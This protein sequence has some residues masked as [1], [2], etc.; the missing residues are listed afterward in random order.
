MRFRESLP[1]INQ[2]S[3]VTAA[4]MLAFAL[5]QLVSFPAQLISLTVLG[6]LV[7]I[8][9][10]FN[11]VV[12][13]LTAVLAAA[14]MDWLIQSHPEKGEYKSRWAFVRHWIVPVLTTIVIGV[15]LTSFSQSPLWWAVF[16]LGSLL[17]L[18]V[19]IAEYSVVGTSEEVYHPLATV[20]L[21]G[22]SFALF[23]LLAIAVYYANFRLYVRLPLL[24]LGAMM[25]IM[26]SLYLR[27]G[28]W[29]TIWAIVSSLVVS[30]IAVGF[31]YLPLNPIQFGI[32]LMGIAYALTSVVTAINENRR[33][34]AFWA[35]PISMLVLVVVISIVWR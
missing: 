24:A 13:L 6:I 31:H 29:H 26:R 28:K 7:E 20:A 30:E 25:V 32:L 9:L 8:F 33:Q 10:D 12:T 27:L 1:E 18:A 3:I 14:G 5:T 15:A 11:T 34:W 21:T 2:L 19:L 22:I 35:E 16:I 4:I 23:L 17:L